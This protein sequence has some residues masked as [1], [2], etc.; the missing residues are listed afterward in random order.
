MTEPVTYKTLLTDLERIRAGLTETDPASAGPVGEAIEAISA[1]QGRVT[2]LEDE[3]AA[4]EERRQW[5]KERQ[6]EG[7]QAAQKRGVSFGRPRM[8]VPDDF[9]EVKALWYARE[10]SSREGAKRLGISQ[11]TFLRWCKN[12]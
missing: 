7:I 2:E 10:I 8:P 12:R 4:V 11:D 6:M 9:E 1:L 3:L 5:R